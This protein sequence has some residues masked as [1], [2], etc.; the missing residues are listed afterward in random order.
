MLDRTRSFVNGARRRRKPRPAPRRRTCSPARAASTDWHSISADGDD[1]HRLHDGRQDVLG[2]VTV[3]DLPLD[4]TPVDATGQ[5]YLMFAQ[6]DNL[7]W[8]ADGIAIDELEV[9]PQ[10]TPPALSLVGSCGGAGFCPDRELFVKALR[11]RLRD[12]AAPT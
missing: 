10:R 3:R 6:E 4:S 2:W 9:G 8:L 12:D 11:Q 5:F 1:W 7:W